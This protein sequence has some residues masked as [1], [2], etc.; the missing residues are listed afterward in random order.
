ML[1][2]QTD[3]GFSTTFVFKQRVRQEKGL[4]TSVVAVTVTNRRDLRRN[5]LGRPRSTSRASAVIHCYIQNQPVDVRCQLNQPRVASESQE[6]PFYCLQAARPVKEA[7]PEDPR[8]LKRMLRLPRSPKTITI[9]R[10]L[11]QRVYVSASERV[12]TIYSNNTS[13]YVRLT[14]NEP[15]DTYT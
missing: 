11:S 6:R 13:H 2:N 3:S 12:E 1:N 5:R 7:L 10:S 8:V 14:T 4:W 9:S 15:S